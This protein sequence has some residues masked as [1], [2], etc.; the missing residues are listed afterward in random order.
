MTGGSCTGRHTCGQP[1]P[2]VDV[3][4]G[5]PCLGP[6]PGAPWLA[7]MAWR[8]RDNQ[9]RAFDLRMAGAFAKSPQMPPPGH[10]PSQL[11]QGQP[12]RESC[13]EPPLTNGLMQGS[14]GPWTQPGLLLGYQPGSQ[15]AGPYGRFRQQA[16]SRHSCMVALEPRD[17]R[18][19]PWLHQPEPSGL[20]GHLE[21]EGVQAP[22]PANLETCVGVNPHR[23]PPNL[24]P[25]PLQD[26]DAPRG[27]PS[28]LGVQ[29]ADEP[30][31]TISVLSS[32]A[33]SV[34]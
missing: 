12:P 28:S 2:R 21:R 11:L 15:G 7:H 8:S 19:T 25:H 34:L 17:S 30:A 14:G 16:R 13:W 24:H 9:G 29:E 20:S 26:S 27:R 22:T 10:S 23:A 31:T 5:W 33:G 6:A 3:W 18:P 4:V 32:R 1:P